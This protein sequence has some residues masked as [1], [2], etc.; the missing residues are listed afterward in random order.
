[1]VEVI[2]N[3]VFPAVVFIAGQHFYDSFHG[4]VFF[5]ERKCLNGT[6]HGD[7]GS[8]V[9]PAENAEVNEL[10]MRESQS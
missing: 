10:F 6:D 5:Y 7:F 1:M 8:V 9:T 3:G 4:L 2:R